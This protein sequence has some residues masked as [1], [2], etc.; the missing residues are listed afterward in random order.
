MPMESI[1]PSFWSTR[2]EW[3]CSLEEVGVHPSVTVSKGK[4]LEKVD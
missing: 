3:V 2:S 1:Q 4:S